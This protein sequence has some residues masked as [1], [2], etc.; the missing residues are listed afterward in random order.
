MPINSEEKLHA[1]TR[2]RGVPVADAQGEARQWEVL[3]APEE[4]EDRNLKWAR[5]RRGM[6]LHLTVVLLVPLGLLA[7]LFMDVG[8][9]YVMRGQMQVAADAAALAGASGFIDGNA[10][11]D[12]VQARAAHYVAANP[13]DGG[14]VALE[15]L[16][17]NTSSGTLRLVLSHQTGPLLLAPDGITIRIRASAKAELVQPGE[18]GRPIPTENAF[19]WW[20]QDESVVAGSD[21][22]MVRLGS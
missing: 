16:I 12:S 5:D 21:S 3:S 4:S 9:L 7:A 14:S 13:I 10:E 8:R 2:T 6:A 18:I 17:V 11:G 22:G 20:R 1:T 19:T 15:S